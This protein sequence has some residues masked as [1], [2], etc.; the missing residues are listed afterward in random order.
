MSFAATKAVMKEKVKKATAI[1]L[2]VTFLLVGFL[3]E[4][5]HQHPM[6]A[7]GVPTVITAGNPLSGKA[8]SLRPAFGCLIC[9]T[10][11]FSIVSPGLEGFRFVDSTPEPLELSFLDLS[12]RQLDNPFFISLRRAPPAVI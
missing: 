12:F 7:A 9:Q 5:T 1:S 8:A 3:T 6:F 11:F 2:A 4:Y 10:S